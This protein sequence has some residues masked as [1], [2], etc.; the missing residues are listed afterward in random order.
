MPHRGFTVDRAATLAPGMMI[1]PLRHTDVQPQVLQDHVDALFP[2]GVTQHG[3][4]YFLAGN[5]AAT[6]VNPSIELLFEYVRRAAYPT[7]PSRFESVFACETLD[8]ARAFRASPVWGN[9]AAAIFEV[10][11]ESAAFRVDMTC[12]TLQGSILVASYLANR[13]WRQEPSELH[14]FGGPQTP[15]SWEVL[16][17]P[18]VRVVGQVDP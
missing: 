16:L 5:Q 4:N 3:N 12:L 13:Y 14:L 8:D 18:P 6:T 1:E 11:T 17:S 7:A 15:P 10:E 2:N 9:P